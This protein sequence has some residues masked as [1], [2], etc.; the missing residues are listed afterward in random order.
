MKK[1]PLTGVR[2]IEIAGLG[3]GP[4]GTMLLADLGA[5]VL[6]IDRKDG[7][8][9]AK[10]IGVDSSKDIANRSRPAIAMDLKHPSFSTAACRSRSPSTCGR[11][12]IDCRTDTG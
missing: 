8:A 2:I 5:D 3:P 6:R 11:S 9:A 12:P 10:L 4:F 1:G 7:A